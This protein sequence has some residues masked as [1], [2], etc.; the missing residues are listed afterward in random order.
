MALR[1]PLAA[2]PAHA[3]VPAR[4]EGVRLGLV[5]AHDAR[6]AV[7]VVHRVSRCPL[8]GDLVDGY[9]LREQGERASEAI[10]WRMPQNTLYRCVY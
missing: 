5:Q 8:L 3:L 9:G 10:N 7:G 4:D 2:W 6:L 1:K